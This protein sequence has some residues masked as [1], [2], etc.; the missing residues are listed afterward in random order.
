MTFCCPSSSASAAIDKDSLLRQPPPYRQES[1][2]SN[3]SYFVSGCGGTANAVSTASEL[4]NASPTPERRWKRSANGNGLSAVRLAWSSSSSAVC[5]G[6][7]T[8]SCFE[9]ESPLPSYRQESSASNDSYVTCYTHLPTSSCPTPTPHVGR[10]NGSSPAG[11]V[12]VSTSSANTSLGSGRASE[13]KSIQS[14]SGTAASGSSS[15]V[16]RRAS[17]RQVSATAAC[18]MGDDGDAAAM[19]VP[20]SPDATS[21]TT[22]RCQTRDTVPD[23]EILSSLMLPPVPPPSYENACSGTRNSGLVQQ[24]LRGGLTTTWQRSTPNSRSYDETSSRR[25]ASGGSGQREMY[26]M[27]I[28]YEDMLIPLPAAGNGNSTASYGGMRPDIQSRSSPNGNASP[29]DRL[30]VGVLPLSSTPAPSSTFAISASGQAIKNAFKT[31]AKQMAVSPN[32]NPSSATNGSTIKR[33]RTTPTPPPTG[34]GADVLSLSSSTTA[35]GGSGSS[36][37]SDRK[38]NVVD[39]SLSV[40]PSS[41]PTVHCYQDQGLPVAAVGAMLARNATTATSIGSSCVTA[42]TAATGC[43]SSAPGKLRRAFFVTGKPPP[44]KRLLSPSEQTLSA[45]DQTG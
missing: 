34:A 9:G 38:V 31:Q 27:H 28:S 7:A 23:Y 21:P 17:L 14:I 37:R 25:R 42:T 44:T 19:A 40:P 13:N 43:G 26:L 32:E 3:D 30:T 8:A 6:G 39:S 45:N 1:S 16:N 18:S 22:I 20:K 10:H 15:D 4:T 12:S 11:S 33:P 29:C 2:T 24:T 5:C 35:T 41:P 36:P